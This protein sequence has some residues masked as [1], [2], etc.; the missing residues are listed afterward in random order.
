MKKN[1]KISKNKDVN[2]SFNISKEHTIKYK[3]YN[4]NK[5]NQIINDININK[6]YI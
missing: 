2:N 1:K 3:V 5:L 4:Y 6:W